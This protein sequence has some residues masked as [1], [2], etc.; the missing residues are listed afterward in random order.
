MAPHQHK[1]LQALEWELWNTSREDLIARCK[2][3]RKE[4]ASDLEG[5][6]SDPARY[7]DVELRDYL[8]EISAEPIRTDGAAVKT[9]PAEELKFKEELAAQIKAGDSEVW[10]AFCKKSWGKFDPMIYPVDVLLRYLEGKEP[11]TLQEL[12]TPEIW[13]M[14]KVD[15]VTR[16][17]MAVKQGASPLTGYGRDPALYGLE[18]LREYLAALNPNMEQEEEVIAA[19][20]SDG[21][22]LDKVMNTLDSIVEEAIGD[23]TYLEP[24]PG[25]EDVLPGI[26]AN[27]YA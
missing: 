14:S 27:I 7:E 15:L 23:D 21:S 17:K 16:C 5:K 8:F 2:A 13:T 22:D 3:V 12:V 19:G 26:Y 4:G 1:A 24:L 18:Q 9:T 10:H 25:E 20:G 6:G 11:P